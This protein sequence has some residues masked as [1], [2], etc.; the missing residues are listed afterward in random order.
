M[1]SPRQSV[2]PLSWGRVLG[3]CK[4]LSAPPLS[5]TGQPTR[6]CEGTLL[7]PDY[8]GSKGPLEWNMLKNTGDPPLCLEGTVY[9]GHPTQKA[10]SSFV[11]R[12]A[13]SQGK[14]WVRR[15]WTRRLSPGGQPAR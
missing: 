8:R 12:D 14:G 15:P 4:G 13:G 9:T 11:L 6:D 5:L 10:A 1:Y 7:S 3:N 2:A